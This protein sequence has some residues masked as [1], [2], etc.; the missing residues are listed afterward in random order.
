MP[1]VVTPVSLSK[2]LNHGASSLGWDIKP[3][4]LC[5][6][7]VYARKRTK[8]TYRKEKGFALVFLVCLAAYCAMNFVNHYKVLHTGFKVS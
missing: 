3:F 2:T 6:V 1:S 4:V 7:Y 5:V 8:C